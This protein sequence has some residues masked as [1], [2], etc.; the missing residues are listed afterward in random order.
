MFSLPPLPPEEGLHVIAVHF[1]IAL[2]LVAPLFVLLGLLPKIGR[3]FALAALV[4][5]VLGTVA[6]YVAVE[7]GEEAAKLADRSIPGMAPVLERHQ[8]MAETVRVLFTILTALYAV[9][10]FGPPGLR[11]TKLLKK[12]LPAAVPLAAQIVFLIAYLVCA[13]VVANTGHLGGRL[14]HEFG[15]QAWFGG[16]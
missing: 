2:L 3:G 13:V 9:I 6:A 12:A 16:S 7:T 10:L 14:V 8:E 11:K 5:M 1:P 15:V 4:L